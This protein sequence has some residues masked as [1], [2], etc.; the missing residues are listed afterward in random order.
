MSP[1]RYLQIGPGIGP[2]HPTAG[3]APPPA[4]V[5]GF[6]GQSNRHDQERGVDMSAQPV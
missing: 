3:G 6:G 2:T 4:T 5:P 1:Q